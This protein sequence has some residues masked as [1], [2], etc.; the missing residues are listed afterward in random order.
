MHNYNS[1]KIYGFDYLRA[2]CCMLVVAIHAGIPSLFLSYKSLYNF[3]V[4]NIGGLAVPIFFQMSLI[5]F[6]FSRQKQEN[7]FKI[8]LFKLIKLYLFWG[9]ISQIYLLVINEFS[10]SQLINLTD[11]R[12]FIVFIMTDGY[13]NP[14][15][16]FFS[17]I[18][19]TTLAELFA[20]YI[21]KIKINNELISY[22]ALILSCIIVFL[23]PLSVMFFGKEF[24]ILAQA[25]NP[26]NFVPYV[27]SSFLIKNEISKTQLNSFYY[28]NK[29]N[30]SILILF[31]AFAI[32]EWK[33]LDY[34]LL[35]GG[36][37]EDFLPTNSEDAIPVYSRLSLVFSAWLI[38]L[39]SL[40][41][42]SEPHF[43]VKLF[44]D[45]SL[46]VYCLHTFFGILLFR[47]FPSQAYAKVL[48]FFIMLLLSIVLTKIFKSFKMFK[49]LV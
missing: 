25:F 12:K 34:P 18:F 46:G 2:I 32:F 33:Y 13:S 6:F 36:F 10:L 31:I 14:F 20:S 4:Y 28:F 44:S 45:L 8:R 16:F 21:E 38:T 26:L 27:F 39:I 24:A 29:K 22:S 49:D 48:I 42:T 19:L 43:I 3:I 23:S 35:W 5:L 15:Y 1:Q 11:I 9:L 47:I 17:L 37:R 7:Y 40:K 30:L 41:V